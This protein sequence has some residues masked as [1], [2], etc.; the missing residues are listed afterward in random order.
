MRFLARGD[1]FADLGFYFRGI[2]NGF[3]AQD[4]HQVPKLYFWRRGWD[5]SQSDFGLFFLEILHASL[6]P[7][8]GCFTGCEGEWF[9]DCEELF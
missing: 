2:A 3:F 8:F 5:E 1:L 4:A 6:A 7:D 9:L